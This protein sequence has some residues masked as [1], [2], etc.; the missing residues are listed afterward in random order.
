MRRTRRIGENHSNGRCEQT[1]ES[2][3]VPEH[4]VEVMARAE[5]MHHRDASSK[6]QRRNRR[7]RLAAR[8]EKRQDDKIAIVGPQTDVSSLRFG[9]TSIRVPTLPVNGTA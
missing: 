8:I 6:D 9:S 4:L 5:A 2:N 1:S 3:I 7:V